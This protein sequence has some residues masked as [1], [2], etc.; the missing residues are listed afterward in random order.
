MLHRIWWKQLSILGSTMGTRED[1]RA[2]F[3]LVASG[4]ARPVVDRV[5]PLREARAAHEYLERGDQLGKVV[6]SVP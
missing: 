3:D 2:V 6:L 1:F 4:R 5:F